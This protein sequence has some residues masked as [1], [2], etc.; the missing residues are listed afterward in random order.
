M[1]KRAILKYKLPNSPGVYQFKKG[2]AVLYIGK[3]S[4]LKARILSYFSK[5]LLER[6]GLRLVE[7]VA[8]AKSLSYKE[9]GS[10]LEALILEAALIKKYQPYYNSREKDDKSFLY[11]TITREQFPR[12]ILTR[13]SGDYGPF[14]EP[15]S[16][17]D[18]LKIIR[19]I[20][21]FR[22]K[23][24]PGEKVCFYNQIGLCPG[25]CSGSISK[26]EYGQII[27][28]IRLFF[29]GKKPALIQKLERKMRKCAKSFQFEEAGKLRD[30]IFS[31][32]HINDVALIKRDI[33]EI[34]CRIEAYDISHTSGEATVGVMT[35]IL[36][37]KPSK[38]E[39]R[40]FRVREKSKG[41]DIRAL[42]ELLF[43]RFRHAEWPAPD[44][45]VVDG[46]EPQVKAALAYKVPVVGVV[47]DKKHRPVRLVGAR[48]FARPYARAVLL[49]NSEAHRFAIAYHR[50][51]R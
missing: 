49:A 15:S 9:T 27:R 13:G 24:S 36:D 3:A 39:Y 25:V 32:K 21:P 18:G 33:P 48:R 31:L 29:A 44:L 12:V 17:R 34:H 28:N 26:R 35:V 5:E 8:V 50:K 47:K 46:G 40:M 20:F 43:R 51:I 2:K 45:I 14:T 41:D 22:D 7:M 16:I 23:C 4:Q 37:G 38:G 30:Q 11:V 1:K 19:K 10:V 6:R 42:S